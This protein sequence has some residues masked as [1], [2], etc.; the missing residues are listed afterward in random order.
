MEQIIGA[1]VVFLLAVFGG[2]FSATRRQNN[3]ETK[4]KLETMKKREAA[5]NE[6]ENLDDMGLAD[7]ISRKR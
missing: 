1:I 7:R 6:A 5:E 4:S 3:R 2:Y